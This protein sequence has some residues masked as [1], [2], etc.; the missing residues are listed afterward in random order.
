M[1]GIPPQRVDFIKILNPPQ[2]PHGLDLRS[3][4]I[5]I[6]IIKIVFLF[7]RTQEIR[8]RPVH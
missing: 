8:H 6:Y 2:S 1:F 5:L 4:L 3:P 7:K